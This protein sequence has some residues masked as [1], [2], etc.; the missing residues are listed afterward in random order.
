MGRQEIIKIIAYISEENTAS[1]IRVNALILVVAISIELLAR[2]L[3]NHPQ[4]SVGFISN[5]NTCCIQNSEIYAVIWQYVECLVLSCE[6]NIMSP[7]KE[8]LF[9]L[10]ILISYNT[11]CFTLKYTQ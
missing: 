5:W 1:L 6:F 8:K 3:C 10:T 7:R 2:V 9:R 4:S 11:A